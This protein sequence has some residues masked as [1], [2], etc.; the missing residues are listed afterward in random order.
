MQSR[1]RNIRKRTRDEDSDAEDAPV[2]TALKAA[3]QATS[4]PKKITKETTSS[5]DVVL[6]IT[7]AYESDRSK[8]LRAT[9]GGAFIYSE[10][11][12]EKDRDAQALYERKIALQLEVEQGEEPGKKIYRGQAGYSDYRKL[13]PD[14]AVANAKRQ[15]T[16]GPTRAPANVRGICRFDYQPDICKDY[17][18]TGQ[19]PF[20]DSCIYLHDRSDY[21]SGWQ[22]EKEWEEEQRKKA[23]RLARRLAAGLPEESSSESGD[24]DE[25]PFACYICRQPYTNPVATN[26]EHYFCEKCAMERNKTNANCA[27][28]GEPT[29]GIFNQAPKL[30]AKLRK[31]AE[32]DDKADQKKTETIVENED[33]GWTT[34]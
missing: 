33:D 1:V 28:C 7:G 29:N 5:R 10:I 27:V 13:N 12:T 15:G 6:S 21:K 34:L 16:L 32:A 9:E 23:E 24:E 14:E 30:L 26:C 4:A 11:D 31:K 20:G 17:K 18:E 3:V 2:G 22:L 25:I 19:C 8:A